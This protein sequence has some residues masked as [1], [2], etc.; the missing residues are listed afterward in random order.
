MLKLIPNP[1]FKQKVK[2][3]APGGAEHEVTLEFKHHTKDE[4]EALFKS[5]AWKSGNDVDNV[6]AIAVGWEG[7]EA[8]FNAASVATLFQHY[9]SAPA[10]FVSEFVTGQVGA[11]LGN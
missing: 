2:I 9:Q 1:T 4:M 11:K 3:M 10:V 5:E 8:P 7:V 6:M